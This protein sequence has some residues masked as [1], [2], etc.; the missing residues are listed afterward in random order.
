MTK[1]DIPRALAALPPDVAAAVRE[2]SRFLREKGVR[3]ALCGGVALSAYA[4]PRAT[5]DVDFLVGDDAFEFHGAIAVP[6]LSKVGT[7][8][9][10]MVSLEPDL[11][12]L[13][14]ELDAPTVSDGVNVVS[15]EALVAMKLV[16]RRLQDQADV[17]ALLQAGAVDV[18]DCR[19]WLAHRGFD[20]ALYDSLVAKARSR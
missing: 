3:H 5:K 9:V 19:A 20:V 14:S 8:A 18:D 1:P 10:D 2:A 4:R 12:A 6:P 16:A 13:A 11:H 15:V 7:I 17:V